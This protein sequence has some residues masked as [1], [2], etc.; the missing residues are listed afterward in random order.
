M[1]LKMMIQMMPMRIH[2]RVVMRRGNKL[3]SQR[4]HSMEF[5]FSRIN[6]I[7]NILNNNSERLYIDRCVL[8]LK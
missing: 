3:P 4:T 6:E 5:F 2:I 8:V 1:I 7:S